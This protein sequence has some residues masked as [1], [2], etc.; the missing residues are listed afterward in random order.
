MYLI[1]S[2]HAYDRNGKRI[3][4]R[5]GVDKLADPNK[6]WGIV[7]NA[8]EGAV[9]DQE[10]YSKLLAASKVHP[11]LKEL[12]NLLGDPSEQVTS[13]SA[14][15]VKLWTKFYR[16]FSLSRIPI[17][18]LKADVNIE[19]EI[20]F[21]EIQPNFSAVNKVMLDNY[22]AINNNYTNSN[23]KDGI[24]RTDVVKVLKDFKDITSREEAYDFLKAIGIELTNNQAVK[25]RLGYVLSEVK[26][27]RAEFEKLKALIDKGAK[28]LE[29]I[30]RN[31]PKS[32]ITVLNI[33]AQ[34]SGRFNN[35]ARYNVNNDIVYDLSLN[36]TISKLF[37]EF[38]NIRKNYQQI[39]SQ[40]HM[41][42][43]DVR[44]NPNAKYSIWLHSLFN[45]DESD[46]TSFTQRKN[47]A[48][49]GKEIKN[50]IGLINI[51]GIKD[52]TLGYGIKTTNLDP[53]SKFIMDMHTLLISGVQELMRHGDK[54]SAYGVKLGK[55]FTKFNDSK[56]TSHLFIDPN[57]F[58]TEAG[59]NAAVE[60]ILPKIAAE[61]ERIAILKEG[62]M[63]IIP[64]FNDS[65]TARGFS[66]TMFDS[67][68][69]DKTK[70]TLIELAIKTKYSISA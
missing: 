13:D 15:K 65:P 40:P 49:Y 58:N 28:P 44:V 4:N 5:F 26:E 46:L 68:L 54:S 2:L 17:Y 47:I 70:E 37:K 32:V 64:G 20:K 41:R 45:L 57:H 9:D 55:L 30:Y 21:Q 34:Y 24:H 69:S 18:N 10:M 22:G 7:L 66:L 25:E 23:N 8:I 33:E 56:K 29:V 48:T 12:A 60:L 51:D 50:S 11:E 39:V 19:G 1:G 67:M 59:H 35:N 6:T 38:N 52:E 53:A 36:N 42:H 14:G 61:L 27:I 3:Q 63:P 16:D 43:L 62:N 31:V